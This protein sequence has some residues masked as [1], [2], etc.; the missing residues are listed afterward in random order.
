MNIK[1]MK[2]YYFD[3]KQN[4]YM[5]KQDQKQWNVFLCAKVWD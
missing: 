5:Y 2:K 4:I 3:M 1:Q